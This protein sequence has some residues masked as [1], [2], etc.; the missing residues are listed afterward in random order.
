M[1]HSG[2][3]SEFTNMEVEANN[4]A[5]TSSRGPNEI[6][7][8]QNQHLWE[9]EAEDNVLD[10]ME[11]AGILPPDEEVSKELQTGLNHLQTTNTLTTDPQLRTRQFTPPPL[12]PSI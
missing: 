10:R 11:R 9:R 8:V 6:G 1:K 3:E 7:P 2:R 4:V 5:D 12:Q